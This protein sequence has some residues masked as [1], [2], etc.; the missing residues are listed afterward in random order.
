MNIWAEFWHSTGF[1]S[2]IL[3]TKKDSQTLGKMLVSGGQEAK[4]LHNCEK[5]LPN[6]QLG[7]KERSQSFSFEYEQPCSIITTCCH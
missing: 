7:R 4:F 2:A 6:I 1:S 5:Q 3:E